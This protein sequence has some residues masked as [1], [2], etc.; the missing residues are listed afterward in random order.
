MKKSSS[1]TQLQSNRKVSPSPIRR[2]N[3]AKKIN[4]KFHPLLKSIKDD[5]VDQA[6][7]TSAD[8]GDEGILMLRQVLFKAKNLRTV[9]LAR[10]K[11]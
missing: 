2:S 10:N 1:S 5:A 7:F 9:K 3:N 4:E 6:D 11:I 8:M